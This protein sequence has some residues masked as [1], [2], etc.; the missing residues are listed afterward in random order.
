M[1]ASRN[2]KNRSDRLKQLAEQ[3]RGLVSTDERRELF[4]ELTLQWAN[5]W[6]EFQRSLEFW[7]AERKSHE[8]LLRDEQFLKGVCTIKRPAG[9]RLEDFPAVV[10]FAEAYWL[11]DRMYDVHYRYERQ[12]SIQGYTPSRL[13]YDRMPEYTAP[14]PLPKRDLKICECYVIAAAVHDAVYPLAGAQ[15][16][17]FDVRTEFIRNGIELRARNHDFQSFVELI[18]SMPDDAWNC[19]EVIIDRAA[20]HFERAANP[21]KP[22]TIAEYETETLRYLAKQEVSLEERLGRDAPSPDDPLAD[23]SFREWCRASIAT[24]HAPLYGATESAIITQL[25][26]RLG[27]PDEKTF[28]IALK[29][30]K[31]NGC[32]KR[33][34]PYG[35]DAQVPPEGVT[36]LRVDGP[37]HYQNKRMTEWPCNCDPIYRITPL[38]SQQLESIQSIKGNVVRP[39]R[40]GRRPKYDKVEDEKR[41]SKWEQ[42]HEATK[43]SKADYANEIGV[44]VDELN[45]LGARVRGYRRERQNA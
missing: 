12:P 8:K 34:D 15:L 19:I 45:R 20:S 14:L 13:C 9:W 18:K 43:I 4:L 41:W 37:E 35:H 28:K 21:P 10:E 40:S 32:I 5:E 1:I 25:I 29:N 11:H 7:E 3:V 39:N 36:V 6:T 22:I 44:T 23:P 42:A 27:M 2:G 33:V 24:P 26:D 30:L 38:G 16:N 31:A 17:P